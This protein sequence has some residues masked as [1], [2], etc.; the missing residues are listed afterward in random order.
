M[1]TLSQL[2]EQLLPASATF[3]FVIKTLGGNR[4][5]PDIRRAIMDGALN[6]LLGT[7]DDETNKNI[8]TLLAERLEELA[9]D[10]TRRLP[11]NL[12]KLIELYKKDKKI[13]INL[14]YLI[15]HNLLCLLT[16]EE[17]TQLELL[18][19]RALASNKTL[20]QRALDDLASIIPY[21]NVPFTIAIEAEN[22]APDTLAALTLEEWQKF[23][24]ILSQNG[25]G[26]FCMRIS[27]ATNQD[28]I[29]LAEDKKNVLQR[30]NELCA[31]NL[32]LAEQDQIALN[33]ITS[34][35]LADAKKLVEQSKTKC[36]IQSAIAAI[37]LTGSFIAISL[38][39]ASSLLPIAIAAGV[40]LLPYFY[41]L[42]KKPYR[43]ALEA[44]EDEI[45]Q[46]KPEQEKTETRSKKETS[47]ANFVVDAIPAFGV[48]VSLFGLA[49]TPLPLVKLLLVFG[50]SMAVANP[51]ALG[52]SAIVVIAIGIFSGLKQIKMDEE[53]DLL[54]QHLSTLKHIRQMHGEITQQPWIGE[55]EKNY[56]KKTRQDQNKL[57]NNPIEKMASALSSAIMG[58]TCG[59]A[60]YAALGPSLLAGVLGIGL[61]SATGIGV[62]VVA[63]ALTIGCAYLFYRASV[64]QLNTSKARMNDAVNESLNMLSNGSSLNMNSI[65]PA[66]AQTSTVASKIIKVATN[67]VTIN[68]AV[69]MLALITA[70][71]IPIVWPAAILAGV[72][73]LVLFGCNR[74]L[75]KKEEARME[76]ADKVTLE[77]S[78]IIETQYVSARKSPSAV[79]QVEVTRTAA[80]ESRHE[81]ETI[82]VPGTFFHPRAA[83][84]PQSQPLPQLQTA[85]VISFAS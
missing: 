79:T 73:G 74:Y 20:G 45:E 21:I 50:L 29:Q 56:I 34:R 49:V 46:L 53:V 85:P 32:K 13:S 78:K 19:L 66:T 72:G 75:R 84:P 67:P 8:N 25:C 14:N 30:I 31:S 63:S 41:W 76:S 22:G 83:L 24:Q 9:E 82:L 71:L 81:P 55:K 26:Y 7:L 42:E 12:I 54:Q 80:N 61:L 6:K 18:T 11:P 57:N 10:P 1:L 38:A 44:I 69:G 16:Q 47:F 2:F 43:Q 4:T 40:S 39:F 51:L 48:L 68:I 59:T 33:D 23:R 58:I 3:R 62:I 35:I 17:I 70:V 5:F 37:L 60:I 65:N 28:L 27:F 36:R 77:V 64:N 52:L 15:K